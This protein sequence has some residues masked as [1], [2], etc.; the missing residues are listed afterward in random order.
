MQV[1]L[2]MAVAMLA[3]GVAGGVLAGLFGVGGGIIVVPI[4][5]QVLSVLQVDS[6]IRMQ[7]AVGT[8]L[9]T[10]I[11]TSI[12]SARAHIRK[13]SADLELIRRWRFAL[14]AGAVVGV[15]LAVGVKSAVLSLVFATMALLVAAKMILP[16]DHL[17]LAPAVPSRGS[18]LAIPASIG[19]LST[20]M[21]IGGGTL[22][23]PLLSLFCYPIHRA[24][25]TAAMFGLFIAVPGTL[26]LIVG[27]WG[28]P[29]LP[30]GSL[31]YVNLIGVVLIA[32]ASYL[33]APWGAA[34]AH[35]LTKRTLS[36]SFGVF[37]LVVSLRMF[38]RML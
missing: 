31:G 5:D 2:M 26:G 29:K 16:L 34:L 19:M 32:P 8:S 14:L 24:V 15:V 13:G 1:W 38:Y 9:A 35:R 25:G 27:G 11:P 20:M 36:L 3:T 33:A 18:T 28:N 30:P 10:I 4:L 21:G 12:S 6:S 7:V 22:G 23:V 37:L 17:T